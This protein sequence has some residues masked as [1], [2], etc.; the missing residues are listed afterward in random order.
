[1]RIF[2]GAKPKFDGR[3]IAPP[4]KQADAVYTTKAHKA[5]RT[6]VLHRAGGRCQ[7]V[8]NG[9]RCTRMAPYDRLFA[10]H[11]VEIKDGGALLDP[12]NGQ[13]LC[14]KHHTIKTNAASALRA[15][16]LVL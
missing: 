9:I 15:A 8:V 2:N 11:I 4:P 3:T 7:A 13:A 1:M 12:A 10:D 16:R 6:E 5:W 14:G